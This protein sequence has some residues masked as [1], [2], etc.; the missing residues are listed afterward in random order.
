MSL[1]DKIQII[2]RKLIKDKRGW[3]LKVINGE[4]NNLPNYTGEIYFTNALPGQSRGGH[5]HLRAKEWFTLI[6]GMCDLYLEDVETGEKMV[7]SLS[8][9]EPITVYVPSMIAHSFLNKSNEEYLLMAYNDL[10][11]DPSDTIPYDFK[12]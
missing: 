12:Y 4:E 8:S 7:L 5:Y 10:L 11:Y 6:N 1:I 3:F 9:D 2:P